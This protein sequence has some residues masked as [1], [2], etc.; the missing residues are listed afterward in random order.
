[1]KRY[2]I[3]FPQI[4]NNVYKELF[5]VAILEMQSSGEYDKVYNKWF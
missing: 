5:N 3:V 1:M 2:G 4:G